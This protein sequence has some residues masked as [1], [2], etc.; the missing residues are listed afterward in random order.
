MDQGGPMSNSGH[1]RDRVP[2]TALRRRR[3]LWCIA[4]LVVLGCL[5]LAARHA[6]FLLV[7]R[8]AFVTPPAGHLTPDR[9]GA[10]SR[11]LTFAS[12]DRTLRA[13]FVAVSRPEAPALL[14]FHGDE[15][16]ISRWAA[17]QARLY[18][19]GVSSFVFDY[20]GYGGSTGRPGVA[21]LA[22]DA[23]A[24]H[25]QFVILTPRA[26]VHHALGFSLGSAVLIDV[27]E[28]LRPRLDGLVIAAGFASAREMAVATG[29]VAPWAAWVLPDLWNSEKRLADVALPLL[30][31]HGRDDE[32]VPLAQALRLCEAAR[33][34][35][36]LVVLDDLPHDA[37]LDPTVSTAFWDVVVDAV[38]TGRLAD[39]SADPSACRSRDR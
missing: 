35:R 23:H 4:V 26:S 7:E 33:R 16:D 24:A 27:A 22:Q 25:A 14:I 11:Q 18:E 28:Q 15:E 2:S 10:P 20:I 13:S 31:V 39:P 9:F 32:V 17:A 5:A 19:A 37:P 30:I 36:R 12:G 1:P 38:A 34:P 8:E 3:M 29:L 6:V 21:R